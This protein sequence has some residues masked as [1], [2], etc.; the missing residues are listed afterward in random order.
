MSEPSATPRLRLPSAARLHQSR[1]FQRVYSRG[2]RAA[3]DW[4][5]VVCLRRSDQKPPRLGVSVSKDHGSAVRRNKIKRLLREAF[6]HERPEL[7]R[8]IDVVLIPRQRTEPIPLPELRAEIARLCR[9]AAEGRRRPDTRPGRGDGAAK[10]K[11]P[12]DGGSRGGLAP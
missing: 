12:K 3:G 11:A 8:G 5:T 2:S 6:R 10:G 7:P 1:E 4:V 9:R